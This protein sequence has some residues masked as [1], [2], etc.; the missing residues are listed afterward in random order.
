[1]YKYNDIE[2]QTAKNLL[3]R[4][5][6]WIARDPG[7]YDIY[8]FTE[9]P[10]KNSYNYEDGIDIVFWRMPH[11]GACLWVRLCTALVPIYENVKSSDLEP[12]SL[13]SI[14]H[15]Q[16]LDDA[17]KRY[18][19]AVIRPFRNDV[20]KICKTAGGDRE[21][22]AF[23]GKSYF[24]LPYFDTGTMYKGMKLGHKYSLEE[25]GL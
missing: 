2:I 14:V 7:H 18:L 20:E 10:Y 9:K 15:P 4:G 11:K 21:W 23:Y 5:Y 24:F 1:M 16:I 17:E 25:L 22:I 19:S 8:A 13:E 12:T 3:K 6:K